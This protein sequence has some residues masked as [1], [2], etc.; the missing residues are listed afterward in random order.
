L[1]GGRR[2]ALRVRP[3]LPLTTPSLL[4]EL[5]KFAF[6]SKSS[7]CEAHVFVMSVTEELAVWPEREGRRREWFTVQEA[8]QH[9]RHDWMRE[10]I[11]VWHATLRVQ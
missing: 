3:S 9:C 1:G 11:Q 6:T 5:G 2:P 7:R 4:Q 8:L 10:A